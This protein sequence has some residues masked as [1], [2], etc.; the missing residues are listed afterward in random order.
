M[1]IIMIILV[2]IGVLSGI[3]FTITW[4]FNE[5]NYNNVYN[6]KIKDIMYTVGRIS[7][8][9]LIVSWILF[10]GILV[11]LFCIGIVLLLFGG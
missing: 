2:V 9:V 3:V 5:L 7:L 8:S 11:L 4:A 1:K 10:F 6:E